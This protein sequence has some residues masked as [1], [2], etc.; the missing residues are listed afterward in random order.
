ME[1]KKQQKELIIQILNGE[2]EMN[3]D[4]IFDDTDLKSIKKAEKE[5][6]NLENKGF[7]LLK[8]EQINLTKWRYTYTDRKTK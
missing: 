5:K 2:F 8:T 4:I 7:N 6:F 1:I 3:K